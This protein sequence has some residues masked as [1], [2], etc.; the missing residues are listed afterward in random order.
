MGESNSSFD[1][2]S[3]EEKANLCLITNI[4]KEECS[5][6][7]PNTFLVFDPS[8]SLFDDENESSLSYEKNFIS[9]N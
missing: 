7:L 6:P 1:F 9:C 4:D 2:E 8:C 5:M 3:N